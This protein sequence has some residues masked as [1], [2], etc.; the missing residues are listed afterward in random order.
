MKAK[1]LGMRTFCNLTRLSKLIGIQEFKT[2]EGMMEQFNNCSYDSDLVPMMYKLNKSFPHLNK[3]LIQTAFHKDK[4]FFLPENNVEAIEKLNAISNYLKEKIEINEKDLTEILF[5]VPQVTHDYSSCIIRN[6]DFICELFQITK[7]PATHSTLI[8]YPKLLVS[9]REKFNKS[10]TYF[11]LYLEEEKIEDSDIVQL[12][13]SYPLA[14]TA[15]P[16]DILKLMKGMVKIKETVKLLG[17]RNVATINNKERLAKALEEQ[18]GNKS[19]YKY[20]VKKQDIDSQKFMVFDFIKINPCILIGSAEKFLDIFNLFREKIGL[21]YNQTLNILSKTPDIM[22]T[23][24]NGLLEKKIDLLL[25]LSMNKY[26][27]KQLVKSYPFIL[28]RSFNSFIKKHEFLKNTIGYKLDGDLEV[29]PLILLFNF[30]KEI[31]PKITLLKK[32]EAKQEE[33]RKKA[34]IASI[35][36]KEEALSKNEKLI[37]LPKAFSLTKEEFCNEI[38]AKVE[39]YDKIVQSENQGKFS[40]KYNINLEERDLVFHYSKYTYY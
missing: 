30:E 3:H 36:Q 12:Y 8:D 22:L 21:H 16:D 6:I 29:Y 37:S 35:L 24:K 18:T 17:E 14:V 11:K 1:F 9:S 4:K 28:L 40:N 13:R 7:D 38:G 10:L 31:K 5:C 23:N 20:N 15:D 2:S 25:K 34:S 33:L 19:K 32:L 27:I 26:V 39:D